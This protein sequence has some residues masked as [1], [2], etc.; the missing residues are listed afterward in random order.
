L[1]DLTTSVTH[2]WRLLKWGRT[3]ARHG[4]LKGI[5]NDPMTPPEVRR[6][7]RIARFGA[8]VPDKP[9]YAAALVAIGPPA[10]KLGQTLSTRP[11][12]IGAEA[13]ENLSKLQDDLPPAPFPAIKA[14]VERAFGAPLEQ[15]FASF[16]PVPVGAA[17][18]AQVHKAVTTDGREVA[19]K[20]L[21]PG[22]EE[23][24]ARAIDTYEWT[25]AQ[26]E[27]LGGEAARLRPRMVV[28][29]F[30]QWTARELD[31]QR[32]AASASELKENMVAEPGYY[33]PQI[34][35]RL[36]AR[37]VLTLEWLD[38]IKLNDREAL[39]E[40][41]QD[42]KALAAIL[43]R[44]FLRQAIVDGFFHAD[45]HHGNLFALPDGRIAAIDFGIMG[46]I[47]RRARIWLAEILYGL[48]TGNY[49]RVAEIHFEA[50]Y[51]PPHHNVAEFATALRAAG[52][53][54]RG[55]PVKEISVGRML[56]SL[57]AIT[58]DF[59]M[60]TQPHLLLLQKTMVMNEGVAT[61][62]DPDINM[63]ETAEP[64][65]REWMRSELGP[66]A[67]YADRITDTVRAL[68]KIPALI[69]RLD[70]YY[71]PMGAAP[72]PPPLPVVE[73]VRPARWWGYALAAAAGAAVAA[74]AL[75]LLG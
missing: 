23:E 64:F 55:L 39:V 16:D 5:E 27:S 8:R 32:E 54:I 34:D 70:Q 26:V 30:K 61:R 11:D 59:D 53:P 62:L 44:A 28:A 18:I 37:R 69:H 49:Q 50:Q 20:V 10:I 3:L 58:R 66:E 9:D 43:V 13:A 45:L 42:C 25:A 75:F 41:G 24:F 21:R 63:W 74:L 35:W 40:E 47:D 33:V 6:I 68:K 31:L 67:Y 46:R 48:I 51:V 15:L 73:V 52:E 56:E 65:L 17:S 2:L 71:P 57:F 72:P 22:I 14:A 12:L 1:A 36:T 7:A 60:P 4:A 29:Q 19:V 38:G